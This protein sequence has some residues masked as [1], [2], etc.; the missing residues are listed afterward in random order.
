MKKVILLLLCTLSLGCRSYY[1]LHTSADGSKQEIWVN[2]FV[3]DAGLASMSL[4]I[5][6][7][8]VFQVEGYSQKVNAETAKAITQGI[9]EGLGRIFVPAP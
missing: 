2:S 5:D 9:V 6:K 1:Y 8:K 4:T 3:S 7:N